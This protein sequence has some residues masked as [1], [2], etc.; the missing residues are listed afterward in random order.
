[1]MQFFGTV[2]LSDTRIE[3]LAIRDQGAS[4]SASWLIG[5]SGHR[6]ARSRSEADHNLS[7]QHTIPFLIHP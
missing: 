4:T 3:I 6:S 2:A 5:F 7:L 1:M